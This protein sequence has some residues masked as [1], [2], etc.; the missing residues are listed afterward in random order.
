MIDFTLDESDELIRDTVARFAEDHIAAHFRAFESARQIP[1]AVKSAWESLGLNGLELPGELGGSDSSMLTRALVNEALGAVDAGAALALDRIGAS[2]YPLLE[3]ATASEIREIMSPLLE[4]PGKL[5]LFVYV[6]DGRIESDGKTCSGTMPFVHA[7][8]ADLVVCLDRDRAWTVDTGFVFDKVRGSGLRAAAPSGLSFSKSPVSHY[9]ENAH[10]AALALSR[11]RIYYA[12]L[13][14]G[15]IRKSAEFSRAYARER[16]VFGKPVAH[17][18]AMAFLI[19]DMNT[20][21]TSARLQIHYACLAVTNPVEAAATAFAET[22]EQAAYIGPNGVQI[23][24]GVGFMQDYPVEKYMRE[25]RALS[26]MLGGP[27]AAKDDAETSLAA[28][29]PLVAGVL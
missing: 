23:L 4:D 29:R 3:M 25:A 13:L 17:H 6:P 10:G 16:I 8:S 11:A 24:G 9:W 1:D 18:Q 15:V 22:A 27:D 14:L 5:A 20:A 21:V 7:D 26:L 28:H 12:S 19:T 2:V